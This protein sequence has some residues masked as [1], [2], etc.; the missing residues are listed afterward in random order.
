MDVHDTHGHTSLMWA[1][2]KG[3]PAC[4]ET[5][6]QWG[7]SVSAADENGF[8]ALHW[9][10]VKGTQGCI[11]KLVEYGSDR[12]AT[13]KDG[14]TPATCAKEMNT[15]GAYHR[16]LA[17]A[18]FNAN[19]SRKSVMPPFSWFSNVRTSLSQFFF[20][21]PF[22]ILACCF[23]A[24]ALAPIYIGLPLSGIIF[25]VLQWL[26]Q[27]LLLS[28]APPNMKHIHHTVSCI[29]GCCMLLRLI[30]MAALPRWHIRRLIV[31]GR[32]RLGD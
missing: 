19:G 31:L 3:H 13:T 24:V 20:L 26:S 32:F 16:S 9:A 28:T 14:K 4:V 29:F 23:Y 27:Q 1:A 2:Y 18:G 21:W 12:Y 11:Q 5:L 10:L 17:D 30:Y 25:F 7:A 6:L 8:T 22:V 15:L